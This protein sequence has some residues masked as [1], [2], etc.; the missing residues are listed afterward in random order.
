M[1]P[2]QPFF[3]RMAML[4]A[5]FATAPALAKAPLV[6][7]TDFGTR[8]GAVSA[9]KGVAYGVSQDLLISDLSHEYPGSL[10]AGAYRLWQVAP[11]W[12]KDT[13]FVTVIDPGVGT[14]RLSVVLKTK[15]G[16]YYVAPNNG[17]LTLV[18]EAE[19]F[20]ELRQID[21]RVNRRVG[22]EDSYT[23]HGRDVFGYTGARLAAGVITYEQVGPKLPQS[24]LVSIAYKKAER[25]GSVIRGIIPILDVEYGNVWSNIPKSLFDQLG[26]K[27]GDKVRVRIY[28]GDKLIDEATLPYQHTFGEVPEGQPLL[29]INSLMCVALA[30]NLGS[31]ADAHKIGS[32]V[33]WFIEV[34][35][36]Y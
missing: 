10:F 36:T 34:E 31:Y 15:A 12:P 23:F 20:D 27:V 8:D 35:K 5:L 6:L 18:A 16:H 4:I 14:Q 9:V 19:G 24:A 13:V 32:G 17:L 29:Y 28:H 7:F 1:K 21:E 25:K 33:D 3:M 2:L 26:L 11:F 30:L 22:S